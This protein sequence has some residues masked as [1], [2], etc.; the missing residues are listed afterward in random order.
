MEIWVPLTR[1]TLWK[2]TSCLIVLTRCGDGSLVVQLFLPIQARKLGKPLL[3]TEL[4]F[5]G[6]WKCFQSV[7]S[8]VFFHY[9]FKIMACCYVAHLVLKFCLSRL[10]LWNIQRY[11]LHADLSRNG[12]FRNVFIYIVLLMPLCFWVIL[13]WSKCWLLLQAGLTISHYG[14]IVRS[15]STNC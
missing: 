6:R 12:Y 9:F 2:V 4:I 10:G 11:L 7:T 3:F 5:W 15:V 13:S 8:T 1:W 14:I